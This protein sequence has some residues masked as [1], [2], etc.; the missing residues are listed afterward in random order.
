MRRGKTLSQHL[1]NT[2]TWI[3]ASGISQVN[4][5]RSRRCSPSI[6]FAVD[7]NDARV[8]A[9]PTHLGIRVLPL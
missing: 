9:T 5:S 2:R 6:A 4:A 7:A 1:R 8:N 3:R